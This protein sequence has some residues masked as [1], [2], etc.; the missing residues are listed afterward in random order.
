MENERKRIE[1]INNSAS[2]YKIQQ[3]IVEISGFYKTYT[4][5]ITG[6]GLILGIKSF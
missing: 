4:D 5:Y 2:N 3:K 6:T 1:K